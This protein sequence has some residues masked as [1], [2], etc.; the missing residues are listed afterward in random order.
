MNLED[1]NWDY[2][3]A[4]N[5]PP[6][7]KFFVVLLISVL[8][9]GGWVY[10]DTLDQLEGL[11]K[12]GK[13]ELALKKTFETKQERAANLESYKQQLVD[14]QEQFGAMLQQLPNKTQIADLLVDVSQAGLA[15]G[16]E[17]S[18]FQPS[19]ETR[20]DF[21]AEKPI[22]IVVVGKYHE[23]GEFV[24]NLAALPRIVTLHNVSLTPNGDIMRLSATAKTYRYL[25]ESDK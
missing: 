3:E 2:N 9:M 17:F 16:L 12:V 19:R 14:M 5:W 21:Y 23:F 18:L 22:N 20:R 11:E 7:I 6:V 1:I 10:Y 25:D 24:S 4:G 8:L 13:K 15:S